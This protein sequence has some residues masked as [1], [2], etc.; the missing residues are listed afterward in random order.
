MRTK[1]LALVLGVHDL[2]VW[3]VTSGRP[4]L[5]VH[6][7]H[8]PDI[9][10]PADL[11]DRA[12]AALAAEHHITHTTVQLETRPCAQAGVAVGPGGSDD[13]AASREDAHA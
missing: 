6:L 10:A 9:A 11:L 13:E 12:R 5:T 2:H 1:S 8:A 3:A 4:S 7:V